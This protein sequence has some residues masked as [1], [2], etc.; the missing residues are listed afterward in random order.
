MMRSHRLGLCPSVHLL[1][2]LIS[3]HHSTVVIIFFSL[4]CRKQKVCLSPSQT[5]RQVVTSARKLNLRRDLRW[6]AKH[7]Q[8]AKK[9]I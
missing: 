6:V 8:V 5:D 1:A 2:Q 3:Y 9:K 7:M 4:T